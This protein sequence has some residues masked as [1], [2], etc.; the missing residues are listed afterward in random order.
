MP[1]FFRISATDW[2]EGQEEFPESWTVEQTVKFAPILADLGVDFLDTSS[3]GA[4]PA[5]NIAGGPGY[6]APFAHAVKKQVGDSLLVG[7]VGSITTGTL[8]QELLDQ[9]ADAV[10]VGRFYQKN[11]G[12]VWSFAEELGVEIDVAHQISWGF[13]GRAGGKVK[14]ELRSAR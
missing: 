6:Q 1:L 13:H 10:L 2:L 5:Q 14:H 8:A 7:T 4:H 11:P 9:G 12:L 3:G